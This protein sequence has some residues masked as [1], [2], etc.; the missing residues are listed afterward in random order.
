[1]FIGQNVWEDDEAKV[2][3]FVEKMGDKMGYR[4]RMDDK[5][6]DS[7]GAMA[8]TWMKAAGQ[9]G[10]PAS[11]IIDKSG[12]IAWIGHPMSMDEPLAQVVAGTFDSA[13]HA[14]TQRKQKEAGQRLQ[15]AMKSG[16][17]EKVV[18]VFDELAAG[19][20]T[21]KSGLARNKATALYRLRDF[22]RGIVAARAAAE[23][24]SADAQALN[25]IVWAIADCDGAPKDQVKEMLPWAEKAVELTQGEDAGILDTLARCHYEI[26]EMAK[27]VEVQ[28]KAV[29]K[30]KDEEMKKELM[31]T[32]EGYKASK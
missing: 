19:N 28:E 4:V 25:D 23:L 26:G 15:A 18:A 29:A 27:A 2:K 31:V 11:F 20:P 13:A 30:A 17:G 22:D 21:M 24:N 12:K 14:E 16:D 8:T 10:I 1:M 32:L 7:T 3:P 5:S 6:V 9:S